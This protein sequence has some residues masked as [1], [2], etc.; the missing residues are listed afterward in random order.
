MKIIC[1]LLNDTVNKRQIFDDEFIFKSLLDLL[2]ISLKCRIPLTLAV[3]RLSI[4]A[5]IN[6]SD[7][8][9]MVAVL[10]NARGMLK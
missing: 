2:A 7:P 1:Y 6:R 4:N 10:I 5:A 9:R 8:K 3:T